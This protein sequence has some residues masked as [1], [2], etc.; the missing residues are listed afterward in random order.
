MPHRHKS[1]L[2]MREAEMADNRR[3]ISAHRRYRHRG[4]E[5]RPSNAV[6]VIGVRGTARRLRGA[7]EMG[8]EP[9]QALRC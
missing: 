6:L 5:N 4:G 7:G 8:Q 3:I 2:A 9:T 1:Y